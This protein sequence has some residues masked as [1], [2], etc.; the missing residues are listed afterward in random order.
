[1]LP[2]LRL[3]L[4]L[5]FF[6]GCQYLPK[7]DYFTA[8]ENEP[9]PAFIRINNY[10]QHAAIY[11]Y[12]KGVRSGGVVR[13]G[14]LP[15]IHTQD[16]GMPKAGQDLTFDYFES[17]IRPGI[18]TRVHMS[19]EDERTRSCLVTAVFTPQPG[20]YYQF[21]LNS[22]SNATCTLSS[23]LV[24]RDETGTGWHLTRNPDVTYPDGGP[25]HESYYRNDRY[26][27]SN[28]RP[29]PSQPPY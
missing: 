18:E 15:F 28:Y 17:R 20:R 16:I 3:L 12:D 23:T 27:D 1:M 4:I 29:D 2:R 7:T 22:G 11:Q 24:E 25:T 21:Q 14:P 19:W 10:T 13:S 9:S 5:P 6:A 26:K 8:P